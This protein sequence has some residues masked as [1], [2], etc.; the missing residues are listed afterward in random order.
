MDIIS[1]QLKGETGRPIVKE[2]RARSIRLWVS[3]TPALLRQ[4]LRRGGWFRGA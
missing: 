1:L 4:E 2:I 3:Q